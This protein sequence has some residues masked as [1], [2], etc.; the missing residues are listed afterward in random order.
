MRKNNLIL[1]EDFY[2]MKDIMKKTG[3]RK[4]NIGN[5]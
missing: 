4:G 5:D 3:K 1:S 2:W